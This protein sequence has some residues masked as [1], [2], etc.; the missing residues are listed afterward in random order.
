MPSLKK[1]L[2]PVELHENTA[3]VIQWA[4]FLAQTLDSQ[5]IFLHVNESLEPFKHS[6]LFDED[7]GVTPTAQVKDL[8]AAYRQAAQQELTQLSGQCGGGLSVDTA[9]EEGR[10][11]ATILDYSRTHG[12]DCILMGTHGKPWYQRFLMGSTAETVLREAKLPVMIVPNATPAEHTPQLTKLLLPTDFSPESTVGIEWGVYLAQYGVQEIS[13]CHVIESPFME[14]Y[15]S[16]ET[17]FD[18]EQIATESRDHPPRIAQPFWEHAEQVSLGKLAALRQH[19]DSLPARI[20]LLTRDGLPAENLLVVAAEK[21]IDLLVIA[22]HG[23]TGIRH[24]VLG[25]VAEK[26]IR[27]VG[28]PVLV[29]RS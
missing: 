5:L 11:S 2:V 8:R 17:E 28:C 27:S 4:N 20:E 22:T 18:M 14:M 26:V 23:R 24:V 21:D 25:S 9:L 16:D 10:A 29:V 19:F 15:K 1:I 7:M 6:L 3:P 13:L 12:C